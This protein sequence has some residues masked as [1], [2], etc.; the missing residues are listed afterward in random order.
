M[1]PAADGCALGKLI[2]QDCF[3]KPF[4][5]FQITVEIGTYDF[6][7]RLNKTAREA[8][9]GH[10]FYFLSVERIVRFPHEL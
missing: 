6:L 5:P 8:L 9:I 4:F 2:Q 1:A 3:S 10:I 7:L